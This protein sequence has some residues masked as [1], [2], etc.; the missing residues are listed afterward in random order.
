M[1]RRFIALALLLIPLIAA[2]AS[3]PIFVFD[4]PFWVNLHHY[5]YVLGRVEAK[6]PDVERRAVAGAPADE[7]AGLARLAEADRRLWRQS[8]SAYASGLSRKDA[9][10][11]DELVNA[12]A[13]LTKIASS[14]PVTGAGLDAATVSALERAAPLYRK[15]WWPA[16]EAANRR[17]IDELGRLVDTHGAAMLA[18]ITRVYQEEW[19]RAGYPVRIAAFS[20]WAGAYSTGGQ[21]LVMSSLD[22]GTTGPYG[23]EILFHEAMHQ[24]DD[25]IAR[26]LAAAAKQASVST[27][28]D[29]LTHAMIFYTAGE[30]TRRVIPG[31]VPYAERGGMWTQARMAPFR[32]ALDRHWKPYLDGQ[33]T[34]ASALAA[35]LKDAGTRVREYAVRG[36]QERTAQSSFF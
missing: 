26:R 2:Q 11:D 24:W 8:V 10:F 22:E 23:L 21:I 6:M 4:Q 25:A 20:N 27:V 7:Q 36:Y 16:H 28:P 31:H 33:G 9:V 29:A 30:A 19:P 32:A 35:L 17:R 15:A 12:T 18:F 3:A 34:L 13:V 14:A 1:T 5:L